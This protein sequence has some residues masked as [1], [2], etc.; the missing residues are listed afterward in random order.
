MGLDEAGQQS[1]P[2]E[3]DDGLGAVEPAG[4][5]G[6]GA[7]AGDALADDEDRIGDRVI[8]VDSQDRTA[9]E[10]GPARGRRTERRA[11][12]RRAGRDDQQQCDEGPAAPSHEGSGV[13]DQ[14]SRCLSIAP[15]NSDAYSFADARYAS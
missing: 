3:R 15:S 4:D 9:D 1:A 13:V 2:G 11:S 7:D 14:P 6:S 12:R 10:Q 8:G 5:L